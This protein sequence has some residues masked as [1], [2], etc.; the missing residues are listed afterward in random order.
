MSGNLR[1]VLLCVIVLSAA[2]SFCTAAYGYDKDRLF[3]L[4][5]KNYNRAE[6]EKARR[7][8]EKAAEAGL[9]DEK[10]KLAR[11]AVA[12]MDKFGQYLSGIE[13]GELQIRQNA[14]DKALRASVARLH[15]A[16]ANELMQKEFF[17]F[18]VEAHLR[19]AIEL[20]PKDASLYFDLACAYY[21]SMNYGKALRDYEK[22]LAIRPGD[23]LTQKMAGDTCV[24][25]GDFDQAKKFY[26]G[27]INSNEK[28]VLK[29]DDSELAKV[30]K[31]MS[32]LP[33]TYKEI[34]ALMKEGRTDEA[35][36]VLKKRISLNNSD[37]IAMTELGYIIQDRGDR[38]TALDLFKTSV[39]I[40]PD[41]P[42]A[43]FY[44]GRLYFLMRE[45]EEAV[46][47]LK[48]FK[49]K[50]RLLPKMD[51]STKKMYIDS[52]YYLSEVYF[53]LKRYE[54]ARRELEEIIKIDPQEQ[55]AYYN[56]G[57]YYYVYEHS[58]S[59]A[60]RSFM[61]AID[62]DP[63]SHVAKSSKYAIEF[64]RNNPDS[65]VIPDFSFIDKE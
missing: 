36:K 47:E 42:I 30:K 25:L 43:H 46:S 58:R 37:Y 61:K 24:A 8:F 22:A 20:D 16:F 18:I 1:R 62:I 44:L 32:V 52:L 6:Y 19:R 7:C 48:I 45:T 2:L 59:G 12:V 10:L 51:K 31:I 50:M 14:S 35:E 15:H 41:Y 40:A 55:N 28:S 38:K 3:T 34:D 39:K 56:M 5:L 65:R 49:E 60:Y 29:Y 13:K 27:L 64:M 23:L 26:L 21:A 9:K 63:A 11:Y 53:T 57:V 54:E 17:L 4:G 33:E